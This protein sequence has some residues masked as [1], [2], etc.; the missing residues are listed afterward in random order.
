MFAVTAQHRSVSDRQRRLN[1]F[2]WYVSGI[3]AAGTVGWLASFFHASGRAPVGLISLVVGSSLGFTL[4]GLAAGLE[5]AGTRRLLIG[6]VVFAILTILAEHTWLYLDFRRQ[7]R[8][9]RA[10]NP[11]VAM[12]RPEEPLSPSEYFAHEWSPHTAALWTLDAALITGSAVATMF[13]L[14]RYPR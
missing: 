5:I 13:L 2:L 9:S 11:Q 8:E 3:A 10:R 12:F 1:T 6:T 14:R 4:T 7:W